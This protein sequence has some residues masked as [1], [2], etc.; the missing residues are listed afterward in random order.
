MIPPIIMREDQIFKI[1][2]Q[3]YVFKG[4][5]I[6]F[7]CNV[8]NGTPPI[9]I[10]WF[11]NNVEIDSRQGNSSNLTIPSAR[12]GEIVSCRAI[13]NIG[14]DMATS[15]IQGMYYKYKIIIIAIMQIVA[16]DLTKVYKLGM[17][18]HCS[19]QLVSKS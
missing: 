3:A 8:V 5:V 11:R 6:T 13:N 15:A 18:A 9:T 7:D 14:S 1:G 2:S 4:Y 17:F 12:D 16:I 19:K 10:S